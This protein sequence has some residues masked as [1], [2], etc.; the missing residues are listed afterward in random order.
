M[1]LTRDEMFQRVK[2]AFSEYGYKSAVDK[3]L[4]CG[5]SIASLVNS[6]C[7]SLNCIVKKLDNPMLYGYEFS[8]DM[9]EYTFDKYICRLLYVS[10]KWVALSHYNILLQGYFKECYICYEEIEP[11]M[12]I[13][14][15]VDF[16][17]ITT[18]VDDQLLGIKI[19]QEITQE[20][21]F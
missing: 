18:Y 1:Y 17:K 15:E 6:D 14:Y 3:R 12:K 5:F 4:N 13:I 2:E 21:E 8:Y 19:T 20:K 7:R 16:S 9:S 10:G 11:C